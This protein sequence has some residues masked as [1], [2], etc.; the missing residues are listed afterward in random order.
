MK[1]DFSLIS[2]FVIFVG[3]TL[4]SG[5]TAERTHVDGNGTIEAREVNVA[6]LQSGTLMRLAVEEG[7]VVQPDQLIAQID[8]EIQ[9]RQLRQVEAQ[10][11]QAVAQ[12]E[13][14]AA[15]P[16]P[17]D[18]E[19]A[20]AQLAQAKEQLELARKEWERI[21]ILYEEAS[22]TKKQYDAGLAAYR[23]R[24]AQYE[25]ARA[26]LEK[27][28]NLAR[29]QELRSAEATVEQAEQQVAIADWQ[30]RDCAIKAPIKGMISEL[31]YE[32]GELVPAGRPLATIRDTEEVYVTVY[33]PEPLLA[34][35]GIG[36]D[37]EVYVDGRPDAV[38]SGSISHISREAEF[39]PKNVQTKEQRVK[40]VY[41]VQLDVQNRD[42]VLKPG[43]P[44]D[45]NLLLEDEAGE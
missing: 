25:A 19:S 40:L 33:V 26:G 20:E 35:I 44:A 45:V 9:R 18:I 14:L 42:G 7:D 13:L 36:Q 28:R 2:L 4:F 11:R 38:F 41:A 27:L 34:R 31:Y 22:V 16:H 32:V 43:M 23:T 30:L 24:Q 6:A 37:A 8:D 15:G 5:C 3:I 12:L 21:K 10:R 39:T 17:K 29:P 1:K